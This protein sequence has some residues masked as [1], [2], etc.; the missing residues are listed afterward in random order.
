MVCARTRIGFASWLRASMVLRAVSTS[1]KVL[2]TVTPAAPWIF[3]R[4]VGPPPS[5]GGPALIDFSAG[6]LARLLFHLCT[7]FQAI[8]FNNKVSSR[9]SAGAVGRVAVALV[10]AAVLVR[11]GLVPAALAGQATVI[12]LRLCLQ[13]FAFFHGVR[14]IV[15]ANAGMQVLSMA[16]ADALAL[17]V[18]LPGLFVAPLRTY[19]PHTAAILIVS[20]TVCRRKRRLAAE[21]IREGGC[22]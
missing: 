6:I 19:A 21:A 4:V 17:A 1:T 2:S 13:G 5:T 8:L 16:A 14:G 20:V 15:E 22:S 3:A 7:P 11:V 9:V 12:A 18:S 10:L